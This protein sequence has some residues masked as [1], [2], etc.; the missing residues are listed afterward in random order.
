M[1]RAMS[2]AILLFALLLAALPAGATGVMVLSVAQ[3]RVDLLVN[4]NAVRQLRSGQSSPEGVVLISAT[5]T[6]AVLEIEGRRH[7]LSLGQTNIAA[8]V[9]TADPLGHFRTVAYVNGQPTTMM[10]D[11]GAS[12]ISMSS[13][14][15]RELGIEYRRGQRVGIQTANGR[16]EAWRVNLAS[17]R[18]GDIVLHNVD[19][20]VA[21]AGR[22]LTGQP[23]LGMSFLNMVEMQRRGAT[24]TLT[25]RR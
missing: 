1:L 12:Y 25:R 3:D 22:E 20:V 23:V 17:V 9:L 14:D 5:P 21:E 2:R 19:G 7:T 11:T 18:V 13:D 16:I 24:L 15:A 4:G 10:I 6:A 8:A